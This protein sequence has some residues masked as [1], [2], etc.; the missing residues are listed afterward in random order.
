MT[1]LEKY[2]RSCDCLPCLHTIWGELCEP[3]HRHG[4]HPSLAYHIP[5]NELGDGET[6]GPSNQLKSGMVGS[7]HHRSNISDT[8]TRYYRHINYLSSSLVRDRERECG[9]EESSLEGELTPW[10]RSIGDF[11][12]YLADRQDLSPSFQYT[13]YVNACNRRRR[14]S[15]R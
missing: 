7:L 9:K 14:P 3:P 1:R 12:K 15:V 5:M 11:T 2:Y 8:A 6:F 13:I 10:P 4:L